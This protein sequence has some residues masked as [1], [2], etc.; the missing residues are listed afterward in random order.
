MTIVLTTHYMREADELC[1]EIAFIK[2]GAILARGT[3]G[4]LK[5]QIRLGDV[6]ALRLDPPA[7]PRSEEHTSELQSQS[8][9]V[10]RLLPEKKKTSLRLRNYWPALDS[11]S[12]EV[13]S[14]HTIDR[15]RHVHIPLRSSDLAGVVV[16]VYVGTA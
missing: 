10:C 4:E 5:R 1:D 16:L 2:A 14:R 9:L 12:G 3:P 13:S 8:N 6:I 7:V 11:S 15:H